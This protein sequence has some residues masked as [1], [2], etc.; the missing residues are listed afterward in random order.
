[1]MPPMRQESSHLQVGFPI[2]QMSCTG[3]I[4]VLDHLQLITIF[5]Q[6]VVPYVEP[7]RPNPAVEYCKEIFPILATIIDT[8]ITFTPICERV[9]RT[10][11]NMIISYRTAMEP[12]LPE[13][14]NKLASGFTA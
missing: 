4:Y 2:H 1:M 7:G 14:A 9:C 3:L 10:W 11:R 5:V 6:L 12:L 13:M 8:F